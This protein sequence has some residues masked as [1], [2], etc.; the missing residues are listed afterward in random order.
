MAKKQSLSVIQTRQSTELPQLRSINIC[1]FLRRQL[2]V[3]PIH[4]LKKNPQVNE[5]SDDYLPINKWL[6]TTF[7]FIYMRKL[8]V[9]NF[10]DI[11]QL[12]LVKNFLLFWVTANS[13]FLWPPI[14]FLN[15]VNLFKKRKQG[16]LFCLSMYVFIQKGSQ[17]RMFGSC[18]QEVKPN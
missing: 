13:C 6:S 17:E 9:L 15:I 8:H 14:F 1:I 2:M 7:R 18:W 11:T 12:I 16:V 4:H 5:A 10:N 3:R